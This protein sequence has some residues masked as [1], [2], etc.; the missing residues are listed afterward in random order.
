MQKLDKMLK[1]IRIAM[2]TTVMQDGTLRSRPMATQDDDFD[3]QIWF[4][5]D[6]ESAKVYEV[7]GESHVNLAYCDPSNNRYV[8][9]SGRASVVRDPSRARELWS[10][11]AKAYFPNGPEDPNLVLLKVDVDQA[12]YWDGPSSTV[13]QVISFAKALITGHRPDAGEHRKLDLQ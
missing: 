12:E 5:S 7:R 9:V 4:F 1:G 13:G 8:S 2:L 10:P 3:G 6:A 11:A